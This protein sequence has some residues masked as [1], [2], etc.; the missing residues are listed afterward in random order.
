M[1]MN[2]ASCNVIYDYL[3]SF[4]IY[5]IELLELLSIFIVQLYLTITNLDIK[6]IL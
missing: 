2:I 1:N 5:K 3:K 6:I 4:V